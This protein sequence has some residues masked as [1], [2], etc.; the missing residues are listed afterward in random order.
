MKTYCPIRG[1]N[2]A[3]VSTAIYYWLV[4]NLS[5]IR[6]IVWDLSNSARRPPNKTDFFHT[7]VQGVTITFNCQGTWRMIKGMNFHHSCACLGLL[8]NICCLHSTFTSWYLSSQS[9]LEM[10]SLHRAC[11]FTHSKYWNMMTQISCGLTSEEVSSY[12]LSS[13]LWMICPNKYRECSWFDAGPVL[14]YAVQTFN[15]IQ[16]FSWL[17]QVKRLVGCPQLGYLKGN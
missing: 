11:V 1:N 15:L 2:T 7:L 13:H 10:F 5:L 4:K 17:A 9:L 3:V 8:P 6:P 14:P 16:M 12:N